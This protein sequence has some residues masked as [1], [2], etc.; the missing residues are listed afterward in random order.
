MSPEEI[1]ERKAEEAAHA[2]GT[3]KSTEAFLA[4]QAAIDAIK[5]KPTQAEKR[6]A[7]VDWVMQKDGI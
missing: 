5:A 4:R 3:D 7:Y 2:N 1:V 6:E